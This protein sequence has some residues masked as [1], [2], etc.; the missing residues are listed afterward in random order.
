MELQ[1]DNTGK[2]TNECAVSD[3]VDNDNAEYNDNVESDCNEVIPR[4]IPDNPYKYSI[5]QMAERK[6]ALRDLAT[7]YPTLPYGWLEMAYDFEKNTD[8]EEI[9]KIINDG[10]WEGKGMFTQD[11]NGNCNSEM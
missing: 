11:L 4:H 3:C 10:L 5:I 1:K 6:R 8:P 7:D 9:K 2:K